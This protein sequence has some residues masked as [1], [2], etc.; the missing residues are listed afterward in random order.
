MGLES[1]PSLLYF[2]YFGSKHDLNI[3]RLWCF[4]DYFQWRIKILGSSWWWRTFVGFG[5][6]W[7][8]T[9]SVLVWQKQEK[10]RVLPSSLR[11][12]P[13]PSSAPPP[14]I[15][16]P[17]AP[18]HLIGLIERQDDK[19]LISVPG[20]CPESWGETS[21][22]CLRELRH[23]AGR[24]CGSSSPRGSADRSS[25]SPAGSATRS[26]PRRRSEE[27][28]QGKNQKKTSFMA[29][30]SAFHLHILPLCHYN[31]LYGELNGN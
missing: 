25:T 22:G 27:E 29:S 18:A 6:W 17:S 28:E 10:Y 24:R 4:E 30:I 11:S 8:R 9:H 16:Q 23:T 15:H 26:R 21:A 5:L 19:I 13:H 7:R 14:F 2:D 12:G 20:T 1:H 31:K 3:R